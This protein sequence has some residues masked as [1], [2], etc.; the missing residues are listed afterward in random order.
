M[1]DVEPHCYLIKKLLISRF[2]HVGI[3]SNLVTMLSISE[4]SKRESFKVSN[5]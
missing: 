3:G 2:A 1:A 4:V 5:C